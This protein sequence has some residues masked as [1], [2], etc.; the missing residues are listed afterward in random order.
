[1]LPRSAAKKQSMN[2]IAQTCRSHATGKAK[3]LFETVVNVAPSKRLTK[4]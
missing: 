3:Q 4:Q 2:R 1:M